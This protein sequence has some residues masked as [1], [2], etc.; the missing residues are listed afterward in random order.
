MKD[1]NYYHKTKKFG[2]IFPG[3]NNNRLSEKYG[4]QRGSISFNIARR[5]ILGASISIDLTAIN[6]SLSII[7]FNINGYI[8][9][10][11]PIGEEGVY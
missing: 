4:I 6:F 8:F 9:F 1:I 11:N 3:S 7:I 2:K 10:R 5:F